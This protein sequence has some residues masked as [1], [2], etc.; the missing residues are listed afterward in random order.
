MGTWKGMKCPLAKGDVTV[1]TDVMLSGALPPWAA[2]ATIS[3]KGKASNGDDLLCM[4]LSTAPAETPIVIQ[5]SHPSL[6]L[7]Q[8]ESADA[9]ANGIIDG[10][11]N[12]NGH[13]NGVNVNVNVLGIQDKEDLE[14]ANGGNIHG[15][16]NMNGHDNGVNVDV[17]VYGV[18]LKE[19]GGQ[20]KED[21]ST[22]SMSKA[23]SSLFGFTNGG[24]LK[25]AY[26][27]CGAAHGKVTGLSPST[28][29]LGQKTTVT[30]SGSVDEAVTDGT[31]EMNIKASILSKTCTG[32]I[33]QPSTCPLPAGVGSIT[34]NGMKCP[35]AKGDVTVGTDVMLS[36]ALPPW[37]ARATIGIKGKASTGDDLLCMTLSTAPAEESQ[38]YPTPTGKTQIN[39]QNLIDAYNAENDATWVAGRNDFFDGMTFDDARPLLGTALSHI[40]DHLN[41]TLA[42]SVY[43][44]IGEPP[45][46]FDARTQWSGL[47]HPIRNQKHCGSCWAFSAAEV[48]SDRVAIATK[49]ASPSLSPE[50]MVSCDK[51][52]MGCRGGW[53]S[54][55]WSYLENTG[56][57]TDK[58]FP[59]NAGDGTASACP[60]KCADGGPLKKQK[61]SSVFAIHVFANMQKELATNGPIQVAFLVYRSFFSYKS[62]VYAKKSYEYF[63]EGGHAVKAVGW[64]T[65]NGNDY[66]LIA[67]SWGATWGLDG[68]FKIKRG[69]NECGIETQGPPYAGLPSISDPVVVV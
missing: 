63:P 15:D 45:A 3:I 10:N 20:L 64:G 39:D 44:A 67:N 2:R 31:F 49:K 52:D 34:W 13:D 4:T 23:L 66:W 58:C 42:D 14:S 68:L 69:A 29:T 7:P 19:D 24:T 60:T 53:L 8:A 33:C 12:F 61:A 26:Q 22:W 55:A 35:L 48:L 56:I 41:K 57:V 54:K 37:A 9:N 36:G 11:D 27:D 21:N 1:G 25:L 5:Q 65:E 59:Y 38:S 32:N 50:D 62:G 43:A 40:S 47:I 30:G 28:L 51:S 6:A 17:N 46:D 18:Q 16:G